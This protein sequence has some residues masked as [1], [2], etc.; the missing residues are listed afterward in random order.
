MDDIKNLLLNEPEKVDKMAKDIFD[1]IDLDKSG[2]LERD[3]MK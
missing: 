1:E 3:E 2:F